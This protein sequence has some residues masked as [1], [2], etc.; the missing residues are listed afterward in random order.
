MKLKYTIIF[1]FVAFIAGAQ[2]LVENGSFENTGNCPILSPFLEDYLEPW[3]FF[4]T[5]PD[6]YH[7]CGFPGNDSTTNNA[8]P[9]DGQGFIGIEVFGETAPGSGTYLRDYIH[10]ELSEPLDSGKFYRISFYV[11]PVNTDTTGVS[12]GVNNIGL[13][14]TDSII[15]SIP[16]NNVLEDYSPQIVTQ[17]VITQENYWTSI[18]GV[19]KAKGGE[20]YVTIGNFTI[21]PETSFEPL[22]NA[23]NPQSAYVLVDFVEVVEN[24]LPQLPPD[25]VICETEDRIDLRIDGPDITVAWDDGI[26][27]DPVTTPDYIITQPGL[28]TATISNG[29]CTYVDS[30]QVDPVYCEDCQL[31]IP[32]AF[33][34]NGDNINETFKIVPSCDTEGEMISYF[35]KIFDRWGRKV[36]ESDDPEVAWDGDD[37][38]HQGV[39]IYNVE[40]TFNNRTKTRTVQRRGTVKVIL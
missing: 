6:Y 16:P 37:A 35:I 8:L 28:Y 39:Y 23:S 27:I 18:C 22:E 25:T 36:F 11:K 2:N 15:D 3:Q 12:Y 7:P 24:D 34:P 19:I 40:V 33:T 32:N 1:S 20:E 9:F 29:F 10:G 13:L 17:E 21:D 26:A 38:D 14:L 31:Y 5:E 30:I 4:G